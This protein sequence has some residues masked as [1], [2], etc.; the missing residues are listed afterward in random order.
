MHGPWHRCNPWAGIAVH[1]GKV[2]VLSRSMVPLCDRMASHNPR[3]DPMVLG[4]SN[5]DL[6]LMRMIL[7]VFNNDQESSVG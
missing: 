1:R 3:R 7:D 4:H 2:G 5:F 6:D